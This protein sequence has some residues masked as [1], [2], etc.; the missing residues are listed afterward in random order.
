MANILM[1]LCQVDVVSNKIYSKGYGKYMQLNLDIREDDGTLP[2][3]IPPLYIM[4]N[5]HAK[6]RN[7][8]KPTEAALTKI[9]EYRHLV[10]GVEYAIQIRR[11][12]MSSCE[13]VAKNSSVH[14]DDSALAKFHQIVQQNK[15]PFFISS[16]CRKTKM[17]FK[18]MYPDRVRFI[19]EESE[20]SVVGTDPWLTFTEFF[21]LGMCP[22]VFIT[23]GARDMLTFSTF[24]YM[25]CIY[26]GTRYIPVFNDADKS[27]LYEEYLEITRQNNV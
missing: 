4:P 21:L 16:D 1:H 2:T 5:V 12:C 26:G 24:G 22:C 13:S 3:V 11:G 20:H 25:A 18:A 9:E 10:D 17:E 14:C 15:G 6:I 19:D 7:I 27:I 23:G 8:M